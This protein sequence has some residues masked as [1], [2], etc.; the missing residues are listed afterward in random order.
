MRHYC[1]EIFN[2]MEKK[3]L[4]YL[5]A[6]LVNTSARWYIKFFQTN[7]ET[8]ERKKFK[9][10]FDIN[11]IE[12]T[13]LRLGIAKKLIDELNNTLLPAGY[14]FTKPTTEGAKNA[15]FYT[16]IADALAL[17]VKIL[18]ASKYNSARTY[19]SQAR[20]LLDYL[21]K[22]GKQGIKIG[23]FDSA[24]AQSYLDWILLEKGDS[25][26]TCNNKRG[27]LG[28]MFSALEKRGYIT[29]N[30][31]RK[32]SKAKQP[33]KNRRA[34]SEAEVK[35]VCSELWEQGLKDEK[36]FQVWLAVVL[37][38]Y[39]FLREAELLRLQIK[40]IDLQ[41]GVILLDAADAKNNRDRSP[42]LPDF[43]VTI[44]RKSPLMK[45][46]TNYYLFSKGGMPGHKEYMRFDAIYKRHQAFLKMLYNEKKIE[47]LEGLTPYS[48]KDTGNTLF[49]K[50]L[51]PYELMAQNGHS[52]LEMT[53]IYYQKNQD[54]NPNIRQLP[55]IVN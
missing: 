4:P 11:R 52:S 30:P 22:K 27:H 37:I 50:Y 8:G 16:P 2:R 35:I 28:A 53:M 13:K 14:P 18:S 24:M 15:K 23:E 54:A 6:S 36:M 10:S 17:S 45:Y 1:D 12:N 42:T 31:M 5:P 19:E 47:R 38:L 49:V 55:N 33:R 34:F 40:N 9:Q 44:L 20:L 26:T 46:P 39:T 48:Y 43:L 21:E 25:G 32:T 51:N 3:I 41:R 7:P 29:E